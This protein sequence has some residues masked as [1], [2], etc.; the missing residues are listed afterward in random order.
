MLN[1]QQIEVRERAL[2]KWAAG[3]NQRIE[4]AQTKG[5]TKTEVT[6]I[7]PEFKAWEAERDLLKSERKRNAVTGRSN[8][9]ANAASENKAVSSLLSSPP[10]DS[11]QR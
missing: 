7:A 11:S 3:L 4:Y 8:D 6:A 10:D 9:W 5:N 1:I 2:K